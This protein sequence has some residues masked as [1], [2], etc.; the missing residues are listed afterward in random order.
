MKGEA[1]KPVVGRAEVVAPG[2][3]RILAP[4]PGP[5]TYWGTNTYLLGTDPVAVV[6]PGPDIPKHRDAVLAAIGAARV[7]GVLVTH[8]HRDHSALAPAL[9]R[10]VGAPVMGFGHPGAGRSALMARVA[11][12]EELGGGEGVDHGFDPEKVLVDGD[13]LTLGAATVTALHTPGHFAGHLAFAVGDTVLTGDV[14]M[15]WST[16]LISPPDGDVRAFLQ[17]AGRLRA[18]GAQCFLPGHGPAIDHPTARLDWLITHRFERERQVRAALCDGGPSTAAGLAAAMYH[19]VDAALL[20]AATRNVL[21][22]LLDLWDRGE[23]H[24]G[25][26]PLDTTQWSK[27]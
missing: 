16:T 19:D 23:V 7:A 24:P 14:V 5:M 25:E 26:G 13:R 11:E 21:A 8:A 9:A 2:V 6:D 10:A 12:T 4:N 18:L 20:P 3:R 27:R 15:G 17:S 22:H 1:E